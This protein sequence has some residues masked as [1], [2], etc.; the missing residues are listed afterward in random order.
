M[1]NI[2]KNIS[3][4]IRV[5]IGSTGQKWR[6]VAVERRGEQQKHEMSRANAEGTLRQNKKRGNWGGSAAE[7]KT[8]TL[9]SHTHTHQ[10]KKEKQ[11]PHINAA[12]NM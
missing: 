12:N 11:M 1:R 8:Q 9:G 2:N 6:R 4:I 10:D 5:M 7:M 3:N